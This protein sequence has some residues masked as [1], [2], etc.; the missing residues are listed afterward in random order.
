[1]TNK[2]NAK[3]DNFTQEDAKATANLV[4]TLIALIAL[5]YII[6]IIKHII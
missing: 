1:M 4:G 6:L 2:I 3:H 5:P